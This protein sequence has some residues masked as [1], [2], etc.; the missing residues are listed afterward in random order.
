MQTQGLTVSFERLPEGAVYDAANGRLRWTPG[1]GQAGEYVVL[2]KLTDGK[3]VTV[4][5][6]AIRAAQ[7]NEKGALVGFLAWEVAARRVSPRR[8]AGELAW[9]G[10]GRS[11]ACPA[12]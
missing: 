4:R 8:A 1:P 11:A 10:E 3:A 12:G 6:L 7:R 9:L 5:P 2:V